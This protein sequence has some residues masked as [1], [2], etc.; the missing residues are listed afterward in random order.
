MDSSLP[1]K[2]Y[3]LISLR[4]T[5]EAEQ[6]LSGMEEIAAETQ[7]VEDRREL[8]C[9]YNNIGAK[10][11]ISAIARGEM[12]YMQEALDYLNKALIIR[13]AIAEETAAARVIVERDTK[14]EFRKFT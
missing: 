7:S 14:A 4:K 5:G 12:E 2:R 1:M 8:S 3:W 9:F 6:G 13:K 11:H 10:K